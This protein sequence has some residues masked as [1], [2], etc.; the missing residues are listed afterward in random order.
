MIVCIDTDSFCVLTASVLVR[1]GIYD[2]S[3]YINDGRRSYHDGIE[4]TCDK[5]YKRFQNYSKQPTIT[6]PSPQNFHTNYDAL[7]LKMQV[8]FYLFT[9][10]VSREQL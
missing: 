4:I 1:Y 10:P 2:V 9:S 8:L 3:R 7:L 5:Y 6:V